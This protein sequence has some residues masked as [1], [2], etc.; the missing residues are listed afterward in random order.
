MKIKWLF[1]SVFSLA[2]IFQ[3]LIFAQSK[4]DTVVVAFYN[5]E[6][7]F[8]AIDDHE[9]DDAEFL[10]SSPK[11]WTEERFEKKMFNMARV[12]RS[13]NDNRGPDII[14][15]AEVENQKVLELMVEKHLADLNYQIVYK[16]S[17][18]NRG[19]DVGLIFK[20]DKFTFLSMS[21]DTVVLSDKYPTRLILNANI[22]TKSKD[23]LHI[24]ANHWPSRRGGSDASEK[25]RVAAAQT[26]K[27]KID[28]LFTKSGKANI[29]VFGDFNDEPADVSIKETLNAQ[30]LTCSELKK[31]PK[32]YTKSL[33]NLAF[34]KKMNGGGS[35]KYQSE[36]D[37]IDQI[38][39]S[40]NLLTNK[41]F[42]LICDSFE[43]YKP[44]YIV[45]HSGKYEG[46]PFPTTPP[47]ILFI[48]LLTLS[49]GWITLF[50]NDV[51]SITARKTINP[52]II[53]ARYFSV[54][55]TL[56]K[57]IPNDSER[58]IPRN[59]AKKNPSEPIS[60]RTNP[61]LNP[62]IKAATAIIPKI[63]SK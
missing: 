47:V 7:L 13:M 45:T 41:A 46:A 15:F 21:A 10:P 44:E 32:G 59:I 31:L 63:I 2:M 58:N 33:Y 50:K 52:P 5:Q 37:M 9:K 3:Q 39:I 28:E 17:P 23:T 18:D 48:K 35:Y 11:E 49:N 1:I 57:I 25:N 4:K 53:S 36:W 54:P 40:G 26:L 38:I 60:L 24:F 62:N 12:I 6:N 43:I 27:N 20:K 8:D 55:I 61:S 51:I 14:G 29:I 22:V 56:F 34:N 16:E 42:H 30:P 19:I